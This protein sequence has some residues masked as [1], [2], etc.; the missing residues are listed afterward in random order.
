MEYR[1]RIKGVNR[2][3]RVDQIIEHPVYQKNLK[4]IEKAEKDRQFCRHGLE[5]S[6][7]VARILYM[8]VL[9]QGLSF[10]KE[11]VYTAALL[12]DIGRYEQYVNQ[13]PHYDAGARLAGEILPECGYTSD[14][15]SVIIEAIRFHQY[16]DEA[17]SESEGSLNNLLYKADKLSRTCFHCPAQAE[18]YW[19]EDK[20]NHTVSY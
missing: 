13:I 7:D 3:E 15:S 20:R 19:A 5:H 18:C 4:A 12:H 17:D 2:M 16:G 10:D 11:L 9:E 8:M 6:L 14:E 1:N